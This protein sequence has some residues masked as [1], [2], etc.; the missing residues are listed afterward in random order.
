MIAAEA[1]GELEGLDEEEPATQS[2]EDFE[3]QDYEE[4]GNEEPAEQ[5]DEDYMDSNDEE[6]ALDKLT[7]AQY[8]NIP[9]KFGKIFRYRNRYASHSKGTLH[10][11]RYASVRNRKKADAEYK[12]FARWIRWATIWG[13]LRVLV[14]LSALCH[15]SRQ[16]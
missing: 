15:M 13:F 8:A 4:S 3:M 16:V 5:S 7:E 2:D 1:A 9:V 11:V 6:P 14:G 12:Y 10:N